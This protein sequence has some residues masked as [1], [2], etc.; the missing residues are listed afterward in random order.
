M[1]YILD[2]SAIMAFLLDE[3]GGDEV[4][5]ILLYPPGSCCV[6]SANWIELYY[7]MHSRSGANAAKTAIGNLRLLGVS[8]T[9][10][11]GED[12]LLWVAKIKIACPF[13]SLGDCYAVGLSG[14]LKGIVVTSDKRFTEASTY[15]KIKLIR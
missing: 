1:K 4:E 15:S 10:I 5:R 8:I 7:K 14:W 6:H 3:K 13:L 11:S 12:F 2:T 9:D